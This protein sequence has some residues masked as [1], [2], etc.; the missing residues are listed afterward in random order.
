MMNCK[1]FR[2]ARST[3]VFLVAS[4]TMFFGA[5]CA[6]TLKIGVIAPLTGAGAPWGL[7]A[8]E[9]PRILANELNAKGGLEVGGKKYKVEIVAYDDQ[10]K[11]AEAVAAYNRLVHQDGVKYM[12]VLSSGGTMALKQNF[13]DDK[14][15]ALTAAYTSKAL[16]KDTKFLFRMY[17]IPDHLG[18]LIA[19]MKDNISGKR[20]AIVNPNDETGWDQS[21]QLD[22]LFKM[23]AFE[24]VGKDL[25]ERT[26]KDFQPML[27]K[28]IALKPDIIELG[29][30]SPGTAGLIIRQARELGYDKLFTKTGGSGPK[31][32]VAGAGVKAAEGTIN[33]MYAD[34]ANAGF[35]RLAAAYKQARGHDANEIL[36]S[37]YDGANVLLSAIQK[38]ETITDTS[39]VAAAFSKAL[40]M[41]S[42]QGDDLSLGGMNLY[43]SN[44]QINS[45]SYIGVI[46]N[47]VPVMVGKAK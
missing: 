18:P 6:Q 35:M 44:S 40:P 23:N 4:A 1:I 42:V 10:Y 38:A 45:V 33:S 13:E 30:T 36:V 31:E 39:K 3:L 8:A 37:F 46:R 22:R 34:P 41:K 15:V 47:G 11:T 5:V 14:V 29:V 16:D 43:G 9:G 27:T 20:V 17:N 25:Y 32:I 19:W 21:V 24:V 26:Q 7:A 28:I 12:I 2:Q